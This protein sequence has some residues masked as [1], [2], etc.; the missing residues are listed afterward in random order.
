MAGSNSRSEF[1]RLMAYIRKRY[2][3]LELNDSAPGFHHLSIHPP[4]GDANW[5]LVEWQLDKDSCTY[6][7]NLTELPKR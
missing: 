2:K 6:I 4:E 1:A 3:S 7:S 5:Q